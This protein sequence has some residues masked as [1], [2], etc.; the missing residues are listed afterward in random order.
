MG[1]ARTA[2]AVLPVIQHSLV[3]FVVSDQAPGLIC[4]W[5]GGVPDALSQSWGLCIPKSTSLLFYMASQIPGH[6]QP[7]CPCLGQSGI[8]ALKAL[9]CLA[10]PSPH[11][12]PLGFWGPP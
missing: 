7:D 3:H 2:P 8:L 4:T 6:R 1:E 11:C 10:S 9:S 12:D 5:K